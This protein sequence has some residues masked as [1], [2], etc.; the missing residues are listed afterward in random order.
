[1][2]TKDTCMSDTLGTKTQTLAERLREGR[3]SAAEAVRNAMMLAECLRQLHD[4]NCAHGAVS[5][6]SV[7][8]N[9][10]AIELAPSE[11]FWG[12]ITP[13]TAPE[14]LD[15]KQPDASS[16]IFSF[17]AV[18]YE[19]LTGRRAFQGANPKE[20]AAALKQGWPDK[21]GNTIAD[22]FSAHCMTV[23]P[24]KRW[25]LRKIQIELKR[26]YAAVRTGEEATQHTGIEDLEA[27]MLARLEK[28][29]HSPAPVPVRSLAAHSGVAFDGIGEL[30]AARLERLEEIVKASQ[31]RSEETRRK[32]EAQLVD[33]KELRKAVAE[34]VDNFERT[35]AAQTTELASTRTAMAQ[36]D[37]LV[38]RVVEAIEQLQT[39]VLENRPQENSA[40]S[41]VYSAAG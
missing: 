29:E 37:G 17:G 39:A 30:L 6:A 31:E 33:L 26:I 41:L 13:Y 40:P 18:F 19:M 35:L 3:M 10:P 24:E 32:V 1:M 15:G 4:E 34:D 8:V 21:S 5:S 38:E 27:R 28:R 23:D 36:T 9:G 16:D 25:R 14:L 2:Y 12:P 20:L 22:R 11:A 7:I